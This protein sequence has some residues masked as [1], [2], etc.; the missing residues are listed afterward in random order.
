MV[1]VVQVHKS[2]EAGFLEEWTR[3]LLLKESGPSIS[4]YDWAE[5]G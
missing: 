4:K 2:R 1:R 5:G 3:G